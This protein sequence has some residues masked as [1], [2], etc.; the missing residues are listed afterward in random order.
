MLDFGPQQD[1]LTVLLIDD[2]LVSREVMATVLTMSGYTVHTAAGGEASLEVLADGGCVP[3]VILVDAQMPGLSGSQLIE[4]LRARSRASIYVI[5]ASNAPDEMVAGADGFLLKPLT[6]DGLQKLLRA[7]APRAAHSEPPS[8]SAAPVAQTGDPVVNPKTL[9]ELREM[10]PAAAVRQIYAAIVADLD[11]RIAAL[12]AA[13]A[14]G[15]AAEVRRIGHA[16]KG[17]CGMAGALQAARLGASIESGILES[18]GNH[19]DN[20]SSVIGD[21]RAAA[22]RLESMLEAGFPA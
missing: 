21:L 2:D 22:R 8:S 7:H 16:I 14:A 12:E 11:K 15:D 5:S 6:S 19:L 13:I 1:L 10:M 20:T 17:G 9:A 18:N 3:S 4:K